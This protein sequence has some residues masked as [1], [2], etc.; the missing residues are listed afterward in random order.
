MQLERN[1]GASQGLGG[2]GVAAGPAE[3]TNNVCPLRHENGARSIGDK[4]IY[5]VD[6][7][8]IPTLN[9]E[10]RLAGVTADLKSLFSSPQ[11]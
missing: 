4:R 11:A 10:L 7:T 8:D 9:A 1:P 3:G 2:T 5:C 6:E